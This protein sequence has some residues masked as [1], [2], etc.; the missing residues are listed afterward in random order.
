VFFV[1][2]ATDYDGTLAHNGR[3][4]PATIEALKALRE[5]GRKLILVTG[6][7]LPDLNRVFPQL[8]L[9]DLVVNGA[10]LFDP[11]AQ[12]ET[13]LADPPAP[14]F[15]QRL[16]ELGV[17]PLSVGRTIVATS[18]PNQTVVLKTIRELALELH[19]IFNK[20]AV[21]VLPGHVTK[22][23]GLKQALKPLC[24]SPHNVVGIGDAEN[25]QAFLSACG[26]AVAVANALPSVRAKADLIVGEHGAG[27][28]QLARMIID[29]D[30]RSSARRLPRQRPMLG[31][32]ADS[33]ALCLDAFAATLITGPSAAGKSSLVRALLEQMHELAFQYCV[34]D[35]EGDYAQVPDAMVIGEERQAPRLADV[36]GLLKKPD[37]SV[38]VNLLAID[39]PDRAQFTAELLIELGRMRAKTGRP[40]WI[41]LD[42]VHQLFPAGSQAASVLPQDL[43]AIVAAAVEATGIPG[44]LRD[45][46]AQVV[47][48]GESS[49]G[50]IQG[51][52]TATGRVCPEPSRPVTQDQ[53][54][55]LADDR[56]DI[57]TVARPKAR[58]QR[59]RRKYAAG[60]LGADKSFYFRGPEAALNLRAHNLATFVL[61]AAGVDDG[62]WLH[63][64]RA[65]DYSR[66]FRDVIKDEDL[67]RAAAGME[68]N[69]SLT[70]RE[71]R[72]SITELIEHRYTAV[73]KR[74]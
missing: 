60:R 46:V 48:V 23:W 34:I 54:Y 30:L 37:V 66:W 72:A 62:T 6:R 4:E 64:L 47:G 57:V 50:A 32:T 58:Q 45:R 19:I 42:E 71:S 43:P 69:P 8:A 65:G 44:S 63:H 9:F 25:D 18:E 70:A 21:M 2:L 53:A 59:H 74:S 27:V 55:A 52:C 7:E 51:F 26:C 31:V 29:G 12:V 73:A 33:S 24:L 56:L 14:A 20:G 39:P 49:L 68:A 16:R 3:V 15:V 10:L 1:A 13:P 22:S 17:S 35:P 36:V 61:L 28:A 40:H 5:S 67:A 38:V 41:V 11:R